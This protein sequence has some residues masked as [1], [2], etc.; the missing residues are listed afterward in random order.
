[1][2]MKID[3]RKFNFLFLHHGNIIIIFGRTH[4]K[5]KKINHTFFHCLF[6]YSWH[7]ATYCDTNCATPM[8]TLFQYIFSFSKHVCLCFLSINLLRLLEYILFYYLCLFFCI[9]NNTT[10]PPCFFCALSDS[11][12]PCF[13]IFLQNFVAIFFCCDFFHSFQLMSSELIFWSRSNCLYP[14]CW[15]FYKFFST[16]FF[17]T[18]FFWYF[19]LSLF[20]VDALLTYA[21]ELFCF[22]LFSFL[23]QK[24]RNCNIMFFCWTWK[25]KINW[26]YFCSVKEGVIYVYVF[27]L[28]KREKI[29]KNLWSLW[30][31]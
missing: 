24:M 12:F 7:V 10:L 18:N 17:H 25:H 22:F 6:H 5:G 3:F 4:G 26:C 1:M 11:D 20:H 14:F 8:N 16:Y 28:N 13:G 21:V 29:F 27:F 23:P 15:Y 19:F 2:C 31:L 9:S 30:N